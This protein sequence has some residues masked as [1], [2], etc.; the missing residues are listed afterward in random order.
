VL[1][2]HC[3]QIAW[4][5]YYDARCRGPSRRALRDREVTELITAARQNRFVAR[6]GA[7]KMWL[8]LRRN[9]QDVARCTVERLMA[10]NGWQGALRGK[11]VRTTNPAPR[12]TRPVDLIQR[13]FTANGPN[14]LWVGRFHLC[15][16]LVRDG[17]CRVRD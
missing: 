14:Q 8:Y 2:E 16:D 15:R 4:S 13:D 10:R 6:Y 11:P 9:G 12:H 5:A 3:I 1:S 7:R 17:V